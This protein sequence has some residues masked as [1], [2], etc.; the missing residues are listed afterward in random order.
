MGTS[1]LLVSGIACLIDVESAPTVRSGVDLLIEDGR[2]VEVG[3]GLAAGAAAI[4]AEVIDASRHVVLPGFVDT[5]RHLWLTA[6]RALT[7]ETDLG[8][9]LELIAGRLGPR[10]TPDDLRVS[11]YFGALECLDA[12]VTT[13]QDY[14]HAMRSPEHADAAVSALQDSGIRAVFGYG[15]P[16]FSTSRDLA[17]I[18]RVRERYF[19]TDADLLTMALSPMGPS[20]SPIEAV[21]ED[22]QLARELDLPIAVHVGA[23]PVAERPIETLER[24]G[25]IAADTVYVHGNSLPD[26]ELRRIASS[27]GSVAIAPAVEAQMG[28]G[29]PMIGRLRDA[30]IGYGL[31]VDVVTATAGDMFTVMRAA[32]VTGY[33]GEGPR[34]SPADVL[35]AATLGGAET[36]GLADR[37]GSLRP[38]K[39]ADLVLLRADAPN[40]VPLHHDPVGAVVSSAHAANVDTVIVDG[41]VLKRDGVLVAGGVPAAR[42]ALVAAA[43]RI[44]Q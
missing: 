4:D 12:G 10:F 26:E 28:H 16:V 35:R 37:V 29:A 40:L 7:T 39:R 33:L 19:A 13:V 18:R 11:T 15:F 22:W 36:L 21:R 5:H 24:E 23:G 8:G 20:Y 3:V 1:R 38:G 32:L 44:V 42:E 31:G 27:G 17:D 34:P 25:L 2:I 14:A 41:R 30:G 6:L 9:Y 43:H